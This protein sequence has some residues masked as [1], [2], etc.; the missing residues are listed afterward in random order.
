MH[1]VPETFTHCT[2][3]RVSEQHISAR[4]APSTHGSTADLSKLLHIEPEPP[5]DS[6]RCRAKSCTFTFIKCKWECSV[7]AQG[8]TA[9]LPGKLE[10]KLCSQLS[11]G[12]QSLTSQSCLW[13]RHCG[14][15]G[16]YQQCPL[17][18]CVQLKMAFMWSVATMDW[19]QWKLCLAHSLFPTMW[20]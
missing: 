14:I 3:C 19:R 7:R 12:T 15:D 16:D 10:L 1:K 4:W 8:S 13:Q 17:K 6:P 18:S 20:Q 2:I 5:R 9:L 11:M